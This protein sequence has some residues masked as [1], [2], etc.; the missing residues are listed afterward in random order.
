[1][2]FGHGHIRSVESPYTSKILKALHRVVK[3]SHLE[4]GFRPDTSRINSVTARLVLATG[5][6]IAYGKYEAECTKL[7]YDCGDSERRRTAQV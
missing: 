2:L 5:R 1:M 6:W 7:K 4:Y 3:H